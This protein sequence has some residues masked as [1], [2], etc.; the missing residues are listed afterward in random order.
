MSRRRKI[1][2]KA[3][4]LACYD[5]LVE[6]LGQHPQFEGFDPASIRVW[7]YE[8]YEPILKNVGEA[9]YNL[10]RYLSIHKDEVYLPNRQGHRLCGK[11]ELAKALGGSRPTLDRWLSTKWFKGCE[12]EHF[13]DD[14]YYSFTDIRKILTEYPRCIK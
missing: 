2:V 5:A 3:E 9:I 12:I 7:A 6:A 13:S 10:D 14:A 11:K 1:E 8:E 4:E